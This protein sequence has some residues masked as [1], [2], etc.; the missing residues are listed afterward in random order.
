MQIDF[1]GIGAP[2]CATTWLSEQ[3][4][5]HPEIAFA[6]QKEVYYFADSMSRRYAGVGH[7]YY[8]RGQ[9]WYHAQFPANKETAVKFGE[10]T[11]A[12]FYDPAALDR[13]YQYNASA[14]LVVCLRQPAD[15]LYSWYCYNRNG[16]MVRLPETFEELIEIDFFRQMGEYYS[17]LKPYIDRF[18]ADQVHVILQEDIK[19]NQAEVLRELFSFLGVDS[20]FAPVEIDQRVNVARSTRFA[21]LQ[22]FANWT[23][24]RLNQIP[25]ARAVIKSRTFENTVMAVYSRVNRVNQAY[26]P[27]RPET[28]AK[29]TK[30]YAKDIAALE[31]L[32]GR[33][34]SRWLQT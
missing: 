34:L 17:W 5:A 30:E 10:F 14:R 29:L 16:L 19:I 8:E 15:M 2:K 21:G 27:L 32:L 23:Y 26:L 18:G 7:N 4:A 1:I 6:D 31:Q 25:W 20:D 28:R 22:S 9:S 11:P 33:D 13:M 12:Y 24:E 3:C